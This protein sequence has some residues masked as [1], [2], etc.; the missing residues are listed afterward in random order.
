M[1]GLISSAI[2]SPTKSAKVNIRNNEIGVHGVVPFAPNHCF[3]EV[4]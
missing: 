3:Q 2:K 1:G 4:R